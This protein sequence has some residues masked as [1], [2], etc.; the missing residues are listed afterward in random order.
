MPGKQMEGDEQQRRNKAREAR[1]QGRLPSEMSATRG[2]SKQRKEARD[3]LDQDER[4]EQRYE[5]KLKSARKGEGIPK[6]DPY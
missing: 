5:G 6:P 4:L 2:A 3:K 1:E